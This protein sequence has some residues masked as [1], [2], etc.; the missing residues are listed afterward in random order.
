LERSIL[1]ELPY[2]EALLNGEGPYGKKYSVSQPIVGMNGNIAIV[3]TVWIIRPETDYP[4]FVTP[5]R[6]KETR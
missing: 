1:D 5:R 4:S 6:I 2:N 3:E